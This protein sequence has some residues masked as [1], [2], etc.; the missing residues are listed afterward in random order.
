VAADAS[1]P[2]FLFLIG[3]TVNTTVNTWMNVFPVARSYMWDVEFAEFPGSTFPASVL[4]VE[5]V[6][7]ENDKV[8]YGPWGFDF[9][10]YA[11]S[12]N[13]DIVVY[14][15]NSFAVFTWMRKWL[16]DSVSS[17]W[18]IGLIGEEGVARTVTVF[19]NNMSGSPVVTH[20]IKVIPSGAMSY[21]LNS[22]K[23]G[24]ISPS[25]TFTIVGD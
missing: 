23:N 21:A 19:M 2:L 9:P 13:V 4:N 10:K 12:G 15:L 20:E 11:Q 6:Q 22:E 17:N 25:M 3:E 24:Q 7:F 5:V 16:K 14:E 8:N 18:G 1:I